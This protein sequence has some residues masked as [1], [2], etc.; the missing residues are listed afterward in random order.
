MLKTIESINVQIL[1]TLWFVAVL[2]ITAVSQ[3]PGEGTPTGLGGGNTIY[4]QVISP[5][6]QP[7]GRRISVRLVTESRGDRIAVTNERGVFAFTG[8]PS[9]VYTIVIEKE[10]PF[11]PFSQMVEVVQLAGSPP[12]TYPL[13]IRLKLKP[14]AIGKP[15]VV[16][17]AFAGVP[18]EAIEHYEK[19]ALAAKNGK[20][21]ESIAQLKSAVAI[22]ADFMV[23]H[24]ELGIQYMKGGDLV[25]AEAAFAQVL[26]IQPEAETPTLN[27]GMILVELKRY[28]DAEPLLRKSVKT[29]PK[30]A[31]AR[32]FLGTALANLGKFDEAQNELT[33]ALAAGGPE[34]K[35]GH[36]VLA[37]IYSSKG[38]K[39]RAAKELEAYLKLAPDAPDAEILKQMI[40][41]WKG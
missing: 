40:K 16:N 36:R 33:A 9:G 19:A 11:E 10:E 34:M 28:E 14:S 3:L 18:K 32:Y 31:L 25:N 20:R 4:G 7:M 37:I 35:E 17:T 21:D 24:N 6:N 22:H 13:S 26:R 30:S 29:N 1:A 27:R 12:S 39:K 5:G 38:D 8:V 23:A 15:S 2:S 41:Q